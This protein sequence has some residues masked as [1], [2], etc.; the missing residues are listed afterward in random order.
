MITND[1][2]HDAVAQDDHGDEET[3]T[4]HAEYGDADVQSPER[5]KEEVTLELL[6]HIM[7]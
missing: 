4:A 6:M 2:V 7:V 5:M 1:A 3:D